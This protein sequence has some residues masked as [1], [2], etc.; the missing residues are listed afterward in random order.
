MQDELKS[1]RIDSELAKLDREWSLEKE[2]F[3]IQGKDGHKRIPTTTGSVIG[4]IVIVVFGVFWTAFAANI[5]G[6]HS[7]GGIFDCFPLFG[8]VFIVF[9]IGMSIYAYTKA[10]DYLQ[11]ERKYRQRRSALRQKHKEE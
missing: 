3:M 1:L 11:A 6:G 7:F 2:G 9:G 8:I 5:T 4:G 10:K